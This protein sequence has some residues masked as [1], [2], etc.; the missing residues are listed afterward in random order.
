[1]KSLNLKKAEL[2]SAKRRDIITIITAVGTFGLTLASKFIYAKLTINAQKHD[3]EDYKL[4][5]SSSRE[6]RN[7]LLN[8]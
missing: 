7:N 8:K 5:S 6:Q 4:E 3:Y 2:A 1:M